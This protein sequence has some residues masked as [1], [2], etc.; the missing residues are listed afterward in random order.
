MLRLAAD[1]RK[2]KSKQLCLRD[3][4]LEQ[5]GIV[6]INDSLTRKNR[7]IPQHALTL[8]RKNQLAA[9][10]TKFGS[11]LVKT[12]ASGRSIPIG[13]VADLTAAAVSE[14]N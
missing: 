4:G 8:K 11:V 10:Y 3:F 7:A 2:Q 1:Y 12:H 13:S 14:G 6:Y 9:V 5:E